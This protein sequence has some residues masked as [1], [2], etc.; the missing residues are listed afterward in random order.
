MSWGGGGRK[1]V[2]SL[3]CQQS[4]KGRSTTQVS[5]LHTGWEVFINICT[6]VTATE[7]TALLHHRLLLRL[8]VFSLL[9][10]I[11][12]KQDNTS[13]SQDIL[14]F[15]K[16]FVFIWFVMNRTLP[17]PSSISSS[18]SSTSPGSKSSPS[19][20]SCKTLQTSS[21]VRSNINSRQNSSCNKSVQAHW[22]L[23]YLNISFS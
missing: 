17:S 19:L 23:H 5:L 13:F 15:Q 3:P 8:H 21:L 16:P 14:G 22:C 20:S 6:Q 18:S 2:K 9:P 11:R 1:R 12:L 7:I 4:S 10:V